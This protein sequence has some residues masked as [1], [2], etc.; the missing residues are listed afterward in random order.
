MLSAMSRASDRFSHHVPE[1]SDFR[2]RPSEEKSSSQKS[3][4]FLEKGIKLLEKRLKFKV[5]I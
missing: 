5:T 4:C 3:N 1:Y 2:V